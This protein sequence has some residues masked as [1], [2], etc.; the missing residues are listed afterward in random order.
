MK[1]PIF[2]RLRMHAVWKKDSTCKYKLEAAGEGDEACFA[3]PEDDK[4]PL[5]LTHRIRRVPSQL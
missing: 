4:Q 1:L 5:E 3:S 2:E